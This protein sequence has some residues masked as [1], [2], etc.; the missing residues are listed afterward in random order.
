MVM[1][2]QWIYQKKGEVGRKSEDNLCNKRRF[3]S[4]KVSTIAERIALILA[5]LRSISCKIKQSRITSGSGSV[6]HF[7]NLTYL[8]NTRLYMKVHGERI[9]GT[10]HIGC[11]IPAACISFLS[12]QSIYHETIACGTTFSLK[13]KI[14]I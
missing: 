6:S 4:G 14:C 10:R 13:M 2:R 1:Y 11:S 3:G 9:C 5:S 12:N 7:S 8:N